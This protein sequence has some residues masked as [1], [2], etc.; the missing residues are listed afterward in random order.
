[1]TPLIRKVG[2]FVFWRT[3]LIIVAFPVTWVFF[4]L[5][6]L[7]GCNP[8]DPCNLSSLADANTNSRAACEAHR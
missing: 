7:S 4:V 8:L 6:M 3:P 5:L 2:L 1:M